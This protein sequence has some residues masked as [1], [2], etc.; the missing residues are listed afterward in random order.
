MKEEEEDDREG[1]WLGAGV[2]VGEVT[3]SSSSASD[4]EVSEDVSFER[5]GR[6]GR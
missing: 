1:D 6:G 5:P 3:P 4:N 2:C